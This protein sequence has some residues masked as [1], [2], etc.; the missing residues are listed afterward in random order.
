MMWKSKVSISVTE[1]GFLGV[2]E[3]RARIIFFPKPKYISELNNGVAVITV[4]PKK[5]MSK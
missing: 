5:R 2:V 3:T 4:N 1:K